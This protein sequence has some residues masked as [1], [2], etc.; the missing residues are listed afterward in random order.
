MFRF[1]RIQYNVILML[2]AYVQKL[3]KML[4]FSVHA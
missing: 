2:M 4:L 3:L 1:I